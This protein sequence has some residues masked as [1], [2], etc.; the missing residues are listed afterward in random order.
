M[1][2]SWRDLKDLKFTLIRVLKIAECEIA[3]LEI[4]ILNSFKKSHCN[5]N[6]MSVKRV[7][8]MT[9]NLISFL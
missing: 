1:R 9:V 4:Y 5:L 3:Y 8:A 2:V 7:Y 6:L